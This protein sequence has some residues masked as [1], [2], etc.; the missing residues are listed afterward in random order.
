MQ[1]SRQGSVPSVGRWKQLRFS[2]YSAVAWTASWEVSA[3][4]VDMT[5]LCKLESLESIVGKRIHNR[6]VRY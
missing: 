5:M 2:T 1:G 3:V 4:R 6:N